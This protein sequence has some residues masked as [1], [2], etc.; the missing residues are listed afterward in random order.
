M[1]L[2]LS[3]YTDEGR[4]GYGSFGEVSKLRHNR[5]GKFVA[6]K[7]ILRIGGV[8]EG[9]LHGVSPALLQE[10]SIIRRLRHHHV[11]KFFELRME[12]LPGS[13]A[14][15]GLP[16]SEE[17]RQDGLSLHKS[18]LPH[19]EMRLS[20]FMEYVQHTLRQVIT[21]AGSTAQ[22]RTVLGDIQIRV[23]T[24]HLLS[25]VAYLERNSIAHLDLKPENLLISSDGVL[26]VTDFGLSVDV[27]P[28]KGGAEL[29]ADVVTVPYRAP[30]VFSC[31]YGVP[32]KVPYGTKVD[33]WS[34]G[35]VV[36]E[37]YTAV[38]PFF[39]PAHR[40]AGASVEQNE[41][42][43]LLSM[44]KMC[45][46]EEPGL[47]Q[48]RALQLPE[49]GLLNAKETL[50]ETGIC[51]KCRQPDGHTFTPLPTDA[52][53]LVRHLLTVDPDVRPAASTVLHT[54]FFSSLPDKFPPN[55]S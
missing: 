3:L 40:A 43:V 53:M 6:R 32:R 25:A 41:L 54:S 28:Q 29:K 17:D 55:L 30:E 22:F 1:K 26:K 16:V 47:S 46:Q 48:W 33:M 37:M 50:L 15:K 14:D 44:R 19:S 38:H 13:R 34:V 42:S 9:Q 10:V 21:A 7:K 5:T 49:E 12:E 23:Y 8:N 45:A 24:Q 20:F 11:V 31:R 51:A 2:N 18:F 39:L 4:I 36:A 52:A 35:C 27:S